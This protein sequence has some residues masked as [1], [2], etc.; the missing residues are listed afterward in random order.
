MPTGRKSYVIAYRLHGRTRLMH[1]GRVEDFLNVSEARQTAAEHLRL[2]R[3]EKVDPLAE[4]RRE[5]TVGTI[6]QLFEQWLA[7]VAKSRSPRTHRDYRTYVDDYLAYEIGSHRPADLT[8]GDA[9]R[10]HTKLTLKHGPVTANRVVQ[11]LRACYGW[12]LKQ[13]SETLP[14]NFTNPVAG[15]E[16]NHEQARS[17]FIRPAELDSLTREIFAENDPWARSYLLL[18]LLTGARGGEL[19]KLQWSDVTLQT[20]EI[21][22][23][24]TKNHTD[25]HLKLSRAAVDVLRGIPRSGSTY[26]FPPR[27]SD[28]SLCMSRPRKAWQNVLKRAGI[29]RNVTLHD[30]RR[31]A[32]VL[33]GSHGFTAEQIARQLNH[34]SNVTAKV[35]VRVADDLQ[36][37]MA[38]TLARAATS[39]FATAIEIAQPSQS[40]DAAAGGHLADPEKAVVAN[41][42]DHCDSGLDGTPG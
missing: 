15:V 18:L 19:L 33:L 32:G 17:E 30:L 27:R 11:A 24:A 5:R 6:S 14:P 3:R 31:S 37:R 12:A 41:H 10:L 13:D 34:K 35:Y 16:F 20:G 28:G 29:A 40:G 38:D 1:L 9:R 39:I 36:Q 21:V 26:V 25:F 8:R 4:R 42:N 22:L 2:I 7:A 23:R